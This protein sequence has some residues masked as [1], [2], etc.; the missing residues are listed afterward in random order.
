MIDRIIIIIFIK[1][2]LARTTTTTIDRP[3][4]AFTHKSNATDVRGYHLLLRLRLLLASLSNY[5]IIGRYRLRVFSLVYSLQSDTLR[6]SRPPDPAP[7]QLTVQAVEH[8]ELLGFPF[9]LLNDLIDGPIVD[10]LLLFLS[11]ENR[12]K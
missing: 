10:S 12:T 5:F 8:A 6:C 3:V 11:T 1:S 2:F 7:T 9:L 4:A